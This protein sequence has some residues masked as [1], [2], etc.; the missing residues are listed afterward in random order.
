MISFSWFLLE[1]A[2][3]RCDVFRELS[4]ERGRPIRSRF[5]LGRIHDGLQ[6]GTPVLIETPKTCQHYFQKF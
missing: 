4:G 1:V 2:T 5:V 6:S 3:P